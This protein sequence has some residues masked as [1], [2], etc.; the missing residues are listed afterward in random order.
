MAQRKHLVGYS[1]AY[2]AVELAE[3]SIILSPVTFTEPMS[4]LDALLQTGL[5]VEPEKHLLGQRYAASKG[6]AVRRII[7]SALRRTSGII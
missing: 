6:W 2:V 3:N 5:E 7:V 4:G 1:W